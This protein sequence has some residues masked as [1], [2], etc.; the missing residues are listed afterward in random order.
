MKKTFVIIFLFCSTY[1][2]GQYGEVVAER[3]LGT[4]AKIQIIKEKDK[5]FWKISN[6]SQIFK[7]IIA[8]KM[9]I[10]NNSL[11]I[12]EGDTIKSNEFRLY[13]LEFAA[14]KVFHKGKNGFFIGSDE[15]QEPYCFVW[16]D[17]GKGIMIEWLNCPIYSDFFH[18]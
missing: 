5:L 18:N 17:K 3:I 8:R 13:E 9:S 6:K 15:K 11:I 10:K 4:D 7:F 16:F 2:F 1:S 14:K 12:T